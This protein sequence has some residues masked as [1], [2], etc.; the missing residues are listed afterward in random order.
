MN[1]LPLNM[2][3]Q[4]FGYE[5]ETG[6]IFWKVP[7]RP[8]ISAGDT[9]GNTDVSSG[10]TRVTFCG[11]SIKAHRLAWALHYGEWPKTDIDHING[12]RNDNRI[13]NLQQ[14]SRQDNIR[15]K[16]K[17]KSSMSTLKGVTPH[18]T[19]LGWYV[20]QLRR[21]DTTEKLGVFAS[22]QEAHNAYCDAA[23]VLHGEFFNP[24]CSCHQ[25][26][27]RKQS[28]ATSKLV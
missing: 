24:D 15:G 23:K 7:R 13:A 25:S 8:T 12:V 6:R 19:K 4:L 16:A 21:N 2:A 3:S 14:V 22:E 17:R 1:N 10:Y 26:G 27:S 9:A 18:R 11:K 20:A 28:V 5:P